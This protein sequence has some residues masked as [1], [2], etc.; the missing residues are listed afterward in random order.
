MP[1]GSI[2]KSGAPEAVHHNDL[3]C[4]AI[5]I[6][7]D[8]SGNVTQTVNAGDPLL[9]LDPA[10]ARVALQLTGFDLRRTDSRWQQPNS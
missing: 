10:D 2:P 3:A 9:V 5:Q 4:S 1:P 8:P 6:S 7:L